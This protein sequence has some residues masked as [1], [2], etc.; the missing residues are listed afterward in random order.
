MAMSRAEPNYSEIRTHGRIPGLDGLR[1]ISIALVLIAHSGGF[2]PQ[3]QALQPHSLVAN[4]AFG[5][6][7][8]FVLSG[9]LITWLLLIEE[10][11][12]RGFNL[13]H[14]YVRRAFRILP[15]ALLYLG[16]VSGLGFLGVIAL[17]PWD[18]ISAALFFRNLAHGAAVTGHF[19]SLSIEEQFYLLWPIALL[20]LRN[21]RARLFFVGAMVAAAPFW[22]QAN[23]VMAGGAMYVNSWRFDLRYDALLIGC[24]LA[25]LRS[26]ALARMQSPLLQSRLVP[27]A[28]LA[29]I[30]LMLSVGS[31][32]RVF[33]AF[34]MS[35]AYLAVALLINYVVE[36]PVNWVGRI[37]NHRAVVWVGALFL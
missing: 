22:R 21:S 16:C 37:L 23:Y 17:R 12:R 25:L 34:N 2:A 24:G 6:E 26:A 8:F 28:G 5:V 3:P 35:V 32:V 10:Q 4:G 19:W 31:E 1:A 9:Y 14:F 29:L 36:H 20:L 18:V 15:P 13:R 11:Q 27:V 30:V 33:R 7:V